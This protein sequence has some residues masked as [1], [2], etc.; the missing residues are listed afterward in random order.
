MPPDA[1]TVVL[2]WLRTRPNLSAVRFGTT[3]PADLSRHLPFVAISRIGGGGAA[4]SWRGGLLVDRAGLTLTGWAKPHRADARGLVRTV[5]YELSTTRG[6]I[7]KAGVL[8]RVMVLA[9]PMPLPDR[10]APEGIHR[11]VATVQAIVR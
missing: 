8:V 9:G 1:E 4:P 10:N 11:F 7:A 6:V 2:Q 3:R 5:V